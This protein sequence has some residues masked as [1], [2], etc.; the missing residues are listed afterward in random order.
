MTN[1]LNPQSYLLMKLKKAR[2]IK[3]YLSVYKKIFFSFNSY[4]C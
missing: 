1:K 2:V 3:K 4:W